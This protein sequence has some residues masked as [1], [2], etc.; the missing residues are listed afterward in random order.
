MKNLSGPEFSA[1]KN[2]FFRSDSQFFY[3]VPV[4]YLCKCYI[5]YTGTSECWIHLFSLRFLFNKKKKLTFK[6]QAL[7][8]TQQDEI[9]TILAEDFGQSVPEMFAEFERE[10]VAAASL[11]QV[12]RQE[13]LNAGKIL[14]NRSLL[15]LYNNNT[16]LRDFSAINECKFFGCVLLRNKQVPAPYCI[17]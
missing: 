12:F 3:I 11:A 14:N 6:C 8:R 13:E 2:Y 1:Y 4:H 7:H 15:L 9:E 10:P 5:N 17:Y 16:W